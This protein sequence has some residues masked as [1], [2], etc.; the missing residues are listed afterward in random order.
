[1]KVGVMKFGLKTRKQLTNAPLR[2]W[3][4]MD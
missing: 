3:Q 4:Y 1:V 2:W